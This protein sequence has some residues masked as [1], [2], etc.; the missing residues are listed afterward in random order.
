LAESPL[1]QAV[2]AALNWAAGPGAGPITGAL[3]YGAGKD[4]IASE[5]AADYA[6]LS[7]LQRRHLLEGD[8]SPEL[9]AERDVLAEKMNQKF[10]EDPSQAYGRA[11]AGEQVKSELIGGVLQGAG[12]LAL[13]LIL[14]VKLGAGRS[15]LPGR[16][17]VLRTAQWTSAQAASTGSVTTSGRVWW[18][19]RAS[20]N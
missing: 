11:P 17:P 6:R 2:G 18:R 4:Q 12:V 10:Q 16:S 20:S 1:G 8:N 19:R 3:R 14:A 5:Q 9:L 13:A 7:E 15:A